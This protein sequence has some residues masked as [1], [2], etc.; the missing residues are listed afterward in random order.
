MVC[1]LKAR[2]KKCVDK[3]RT[4]AAKL[5]VH[6]QS[7]KNL[8]QNRSAS[9]VCGKIENFLSN[10]SRGKFMDNLVSNNFSRFKIFPQSNEMLHHK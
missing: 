6:I 9:F 3:F 2:Q 1:T 4:L 8:I 5:T 7:K 10:F